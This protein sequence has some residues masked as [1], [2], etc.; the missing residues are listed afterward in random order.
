MRDMKKIL[1]S[2]LAVGLLVSI[3]ITSTLAY[4]KAGGN[5]EAAVTNTF[6]AAGNG[7][8]IVKDGFHLKEHVYD[9]ATGKLTKEW[10][11]QGNTYESLAPE[12][13]L[14]K[15]PTLFVDLEEGA[16]AYVFVKVTNTTHPGNLLYETE[17]STSTGGTGSDQPGYGVATAPN[18]MPANGIGSEWQILGQGQEQSD[19]KG[20]Q[21][22]FFYYKGNPG[23]AN[24]QDGVITGIEGIDIDGV[25]ILGGIATEEGKKKGWENGAVKTA[26]SL[27]DI[28]SKEKGM[29][30]G[31]LKF[32]AYA[33]Q[34]QGFDS[35]LDAFQKCFPEETVIP[36]GGGRR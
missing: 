12:Q 4:L 27:H 13:T 15:D 10:T 20:V 19:G 33:C 30:L 7:E 25:K 11:E 18:I 1:M 24:I 16:K 23:N 29:Q 6:V 9:N 2:G 34:A 36:I 32:Q 21:D 26:K 5:G 3:S 14:P 22:T 17:G 28:D 8:L 31:N 35:P